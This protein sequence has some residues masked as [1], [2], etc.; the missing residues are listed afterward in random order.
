MPSIASVLG[1]AAMASAL[2][3][4]SAN[5]IGKK[6]F[7][8][9]VKYNP[10]FQPSTSAVGRGQRRDDG[11]TPAHD[12]PTRP[13]SEFY[14]ELEIG[15]PPQKMNLLFDTGSSDLWMFGANATGTIAQDQSRWN[16]SNSTTA[17]L[18]KDATWYI[19][20]GD[21]SGGK[22][23]VYQDVVSLAGLKISG[24]GVESATEVY[25]QY[26]GSNILGSPISGIVGFAFD[27]LNHAKPQVKTPFSNMKS[28]LAKP[29]FT[30]DL[31]HQ[32]DGTFGFG[33]I[34]KTKYTGNLTYSKIDNSKG[35]WTFTS[36]GYAVNNGTFVAHSMTGIMDT[37]S[38]S[39]SV[40]SPAYNAYTAAIPNFDGSGS[41]ACD[42]VLPDFYFGVGG[43]S[44]IKVEGK[45]LKQANQDGSCA[46]RLYDTGGGNSA[47]FGSPFMLGAYVVF[48]DGANGA[49][50]GW[51][52]S[53]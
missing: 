2:V 36:P 8:I 16:A 41:I 20:Y 44:T 11:S 21:G 38:S 42:T 13:E 50:A 43:K 28:H 15:T 6:E 53:A 17:T 12:S 4:R 19:H 47:T 5:I 25:S 37:G 51:A 49:R 39:S 48:E 45:H 18:V 40:P 34:D 33:F 9:D 10:N 30:V 3:T 26:S 24:Q 31:R 7:T 14:A 27:R 46:L 1:F 35:F 23:V 52:N 22:G 29:V 32:A